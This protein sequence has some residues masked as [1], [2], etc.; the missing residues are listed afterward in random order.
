MTTFLKQAFKFLKCF[1][2]YA[3]NHSIR[4]LTRSKSKAELIFPGKK[5]VI[6][7]SARIINAVCM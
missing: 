7:Y 3:D 4:V 1:T 6:N 2:H 5:K